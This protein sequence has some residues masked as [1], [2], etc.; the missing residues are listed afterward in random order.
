[1]Q[2]SANVFYE[3]IKIFRKKKD[4]QFT[5]I[6]HIKEISDLVNC[7]NFGETVLGTFKCAHSRGNTSCPFM[8]KAD[9]AS[10]PKRSDKITARFNCI[11]TTL[12][13]A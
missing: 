4:S 9:T 8:S 6:V 7:R 11:S 5:K 3:I 13:I 10:G 2:T 1:M 12:Y